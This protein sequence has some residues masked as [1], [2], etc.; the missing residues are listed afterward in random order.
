MAGYLASEFIE[1]LSQLN[2]INLLI[3]KSQQCNTLL[4][5]LEIADLKKID[6]LK[7]RSEDQHNTHI[8]S[9]PDDIIIY[10]CG[11]SLSFWDI[12][13]LQL[14]CKY[15][16]DL[17]YNE[18]KV[19]RLLEHLVYKRWIDIGKG[20]K[21]KRMLEYNTNEFP[22]YIQLAETLFDGPT[23]GGIKYIHKEDAITT[24]YELCF[25]LHYC[26]SLSEK[27][28]YV[29]GWKH[30]RH[31]KSSMS[32]WPISKSDCIRGWGIRIRNDNVCVG[33]FKQDI[34]TYGKKLNA[35]G[36]FT[37]GNFTACGLE[38]QGI[39]KCYEGDGIFVTYEGEFHE[40]DFIC[41]SV[42]GPYSRVSGSFSRPSAMHASDLSMECRI[43]FCEDGVDI[44]VNFDGKYLSM[45]LISTMTSS[46]SKILYAA[47]LCRN[48][49]DGIFDTI[50]AL[51]FRVTDRFSDRFYCQYC[52][53]NCFLGTLDITKRHSMMTVKPHCSCMKCVKK[54]RSGSEYWKSI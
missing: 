6:Y 42:T 5:D 24:W 13:N 33:Y 34:M 20:F 25:I 48:Y 3:Q 36:S 18:A 29:F 2:C 51:L 27:S 14:T 21:A 11:F 44:N 35:T 22:S 23:I 7:K 49:H 32:G 41:G 52:I 30:C 47:K 10:I 40:G 54:P 38:G 8:I 39:I 53:A 4:T 1:V 43:E 15:L 46:R 12:V 28:E 45:E 17:F 9:L 37:Y 31:E 26:K 50:P 19:R 16:M